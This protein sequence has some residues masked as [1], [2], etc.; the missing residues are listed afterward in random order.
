[1][2]PVMVANA[3][4]DP[5]ALV[6]I[7]GNKKPTITPANIDDRR[8]WMVYTRKPIGKVFNK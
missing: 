5:D 8:F 1:M 4:K 6:G 7:F 3:A 2:D